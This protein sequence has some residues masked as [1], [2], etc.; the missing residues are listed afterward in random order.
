MASVNLSTSPWLIRVFD[1]VP[2]PLPATGLL[3]ALAYFLF[4]IMLAL[5]LSPAL[6]REYLDWGEGFPLVLG[7]HLFVSIMF[8]YL[9]VAGYYG[10]REAVRDFIS[11]RP[12]LSCTDIEFEHWLARLR[13]VARVPLYV[14]TAVALSAGF[15]NASPAT[16]WADIGGVQVQQGIE[17]FLGAFVLL[18]LLAMELASAFLFTQVAGRFARIELL[19]LQLIA[20]FSR[21]AL[22]GVLVLM[23]FSAMLSLGVTWLYSFEVFLGDV[24]PLVVAMSSFTA[25]AIFLIPLIPLQRRIRAA[26]QNE[27][28]RVRA[29]IARDSDARVV[30]DE[31]WAPR[32]DLITYEQR[33]EQVSTWAFN[34]PTVVR[35]LLYVSIGIG[36]WLGAAF[37]ERWLGSLLGS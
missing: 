28:A 11:L 37:V 33:I 26:K 4:V 10:L 21:R 3:V 1:R 31:D 27:L 16:N 29:A 18:R 25:A 24:G 30:G 15:A 35:F 8:G 14:G 32:C 17:A 34:T 36:S 20:P 12:A 7:G 9:A 23:L 19:D 13:H 2:L 5:V 22:R 6:A